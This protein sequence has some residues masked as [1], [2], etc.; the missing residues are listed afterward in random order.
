M[1]PSVERVSV[2]DM[3]NEHG[4]PAPGS[5]PAA[6][7]A[8]AP[9]IEW[10]DSGMRTSYANV[11]NASSTREEF[12]IFFGTNLTWNPAEAKALKVRLNDRIVLGPYAAKR[13][14]ILLG[15]M[16]KEYE[17]RFGALNMELPRTEARA[18]R[19]ERTGG[20]AP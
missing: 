20:T 11:V 16:L 8:A 18:Q 17:T 15:T 4:D 9:K 7:S 13:L 3:S 12:T 14:W 10:D 5:T 1:F 19:G 6:S 2:T